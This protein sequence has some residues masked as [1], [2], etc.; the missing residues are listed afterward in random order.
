MDWNTKG[1]E[2]ELKFQHHL[3]GDSGS[4]NLGTK[5]RRFDRRLAFR[6]PADGSTIEED[7]DAGDGATGYS[8]HVEISR[9]LGD[10]FDVD[11][12]GIK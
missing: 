9:T 11:M 4:D 8:D 12:I 1:T 6:V 10:R 2:V 7:K 3:S 5:G